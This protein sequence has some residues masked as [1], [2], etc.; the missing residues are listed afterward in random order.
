MNWLQWPLLLTSLVLQVIVISALLRGAYR[1]Y[2]FVFAYS[3]VLLLTTVVDAAVWSNVG[4]V[5]KS[6]APF[7]YRN[8]ILRQ[9]LLFVVVVALFDRVLRRML[10]QV[11]VHFFLTI[12]AASAGLISLYVHWVERT[13]FIL[14]MTR[15]ARDLS[16]GSVILVL[17]LWSILISSR[18]RESQ[19]LMLA[20]GL[21]LQFTGEAIGQSLRQISQHSLTILWAGNLL[22][23]FSHLLRLYVWWEAFRKEPAT[24][25]SGGEKKTVDSPRPWIPYQATGSD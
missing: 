7:Y 13:D 18:I 15:A 17:L 1:K 6:L 22:L 8:E 25:I 9:V 10:P 5:P 24:G 20:G 12:A 23:V 16:F 11:R 14:S 19:I 21:G 3:L 4:K 2:P